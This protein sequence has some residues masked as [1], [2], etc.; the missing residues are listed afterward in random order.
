MADQLAFPWTSTLTTRELL[1]QL[2][3]VGPWRA[4]EHEREALDFKETPATTATPKHALKSATERLRTD[5][6]ETAISF[7]NARGGTV[8]IGVRDHAAEDEAVVPGI[9]LDDWRPDDVRQMVYSRTVPHL[10]VDP[11]LEVV[12]ER[13]VLLVRVSSGPDIYGT[14]QGVFKHRQGDQNLPLD[15]ATMKALRAA[16]GQYD[17]SA[18]PVPAGQASISRAALEEAANRLRRRGHD[19]L[20]AAAE[21]DPRQF[22][23]DTGLIDR[24]GRLL[25]AALLLYGTE[26]ALREHIP[27]WGVLL[28]TTP[29]PGAEGSILL[30][31]DDARKPLILLLDE[32]LGRLALLLRSEAIR[33]GAEQIEL[34]DYPPDALRE[35]VVN[36][37]VHRDWEA[38]GVVEVIHSPDEMTIS[39]PGGLLPTLDVSRLLR[40]TAPRNSLLARE[41][42]RLRFA[43]QAGMG[44]DRVYRELATIGKRPPDVVD[45]PRFTVTLHGGQGDSVLARYVMT[46][47]PNELRSDVDVLLLLAYLRDNKTVS[48]PK[49][50]ALL[51]RNVSEVQRVLERTERAD[52]IESTRGTARRQFPSYRLGSSAL[53]ALRVG[54]RYRTETIDSDDKKLIRHLRRNGRITNADVRDYLDCDVYTARNRLGRLRKKGWIDFAPDSVRRGPDVVY[55]KLDKL[56]EDSDSADV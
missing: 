30:R 6:I 56:D 42:T 23:R 37:F 24:E 20:A 43:E 55:V 41:M 31:K 15:E 4:S 11:V 1:L 14:T 53:A 50:A 48:A 39:S 47:L 45:G 8:V 28:R 36:A 16:R 22:L 13:P 51:Q 29:S 40:E 46:G 2:P 9:D 19:D 38:A 7:A 18:E 3:E 12:H 17:W 54:L 10:L 27:N 34:V 35:L 52:V 32:L 25:R 21:V 33:A 5:I 44:F 49:V 26:Q